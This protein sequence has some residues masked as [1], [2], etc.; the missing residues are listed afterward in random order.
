MLSEFISGSIT[1]L[2][3]VLTVAVIHLITS[4]TRP[5][6]QAPRPNS[7][8]GIISYA[9]TVPPLTFALL[10]LINVNHEPIWLAG[11]ALTL[12]FGFHLVRLVWRTRAERQS[13]RAHAKPNPEELKQRIDEK[14]RELGMGKYAANDLDKQIEQA[15]LKQLIGPADYPE[16]D[17]DEELAKAERA[18]NQ[19][20]RKPDHS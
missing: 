14:E 5:D 3:V 12:F 7:P 8:L 17:L 20:A 1:G 19:A 16:M 4:R 15:Q 11:E 2:F 18:R 6:A 10:M 9:V 13:R